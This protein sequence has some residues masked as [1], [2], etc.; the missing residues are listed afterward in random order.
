MKKC[1][2]DGVHYLQL[3]MKKLSGKYIE[4]YVQKGNGK[5]KKIKLRSNRIRKKSLQLK[6]G[7]KPDGKKMRIKV[8]TYRKVKGKKKYSGWSKSITVK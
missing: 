1:T 7:Y 3:D 5:Y 8:R 4:L 6:I 2:P